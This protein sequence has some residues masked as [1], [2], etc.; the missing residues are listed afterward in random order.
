MTRITRGENMQRAHFEIPIKAGDG[1]QANTTAVHV[2]V[3]LQSA[4]VHVNVT[5]AGGAKLKVTGG[6]AKFDKATQTLTF[7]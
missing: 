2:H 7:E 6:N 4:I 1:V 5:G 3:A